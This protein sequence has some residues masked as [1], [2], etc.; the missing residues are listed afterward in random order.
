MV[1]DASLS[2]GSNI[3]GWATKMTD[4][5]TWAWTG[6]GGLLYYGS[7]AKGEHKNN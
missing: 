2:G 6:L 1:E 3:E 5:T 4:L 7:V